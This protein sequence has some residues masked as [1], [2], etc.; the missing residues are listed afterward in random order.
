MN[1]TLAAGSRNSECQETFSLEFRVLAVRRGRWRCA[2]RGGG[3]WPP[4][5]LRGG[6]SGAGSGL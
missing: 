6:I 2:L 4:T 3:Y 1:A 5:R